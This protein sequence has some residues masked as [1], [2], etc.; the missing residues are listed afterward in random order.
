MLAGFTIGL[1]GGLIGLILSTLRLPALLGP[2]GETAHR[3]VG[4][5]VVVGFWL[6]VAAV[7]GH[8]PTG[9]DWSLMAFGAAAS[10][11]G[12]LIGSRLTGRLSE[13]R[14]RVAIAAVLVIVGAT[15]VGQAAL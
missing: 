10:V 14:L 9:V 15:M 6:G 1:L 8:L 2:I 7:I 11:P 12:A 5:N 4:T 13:Q 3:A